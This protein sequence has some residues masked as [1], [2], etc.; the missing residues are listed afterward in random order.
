MEGPIPITAETERAGVGHPSE[1]EVK[2]G[3][4]G[5]T[6]AGG[7][8]AVDFGIPPVLRQHFERI[9]KQAAIPEG[10]GANEPAQSRGMELLRDD[11]K[12]LRVES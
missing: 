9:Q 2:R 3:P 8:S 4:Q 7:R 10:Q 1:A 6:P 11:A 12:L 5:A